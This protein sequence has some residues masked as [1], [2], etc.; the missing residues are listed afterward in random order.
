MA[1]YR[2]SKINLSIHYII[3]IKVN[4]IILNMIAFILFPNR[5]KSQNIVIEQK[6]DNSC[7]KM[8]IQK[9]QDFAFSFF[10]R[11]EGFK[12]LLLKPSSPLTL[13]LERL[14]KLMTCMSRP[15]RLLHVN[16]GR[17]ISRGIISFFVI[18]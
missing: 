12:Q 2:L 18:C 7:N 11:G 13:A 8:I 17:R 4:T 6:E 15:I 9:I 1:K 3:I 5:K 10:V 16:S 14:L